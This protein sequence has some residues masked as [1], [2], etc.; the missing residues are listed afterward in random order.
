MGRLKNSLS[1]EQLVAGDDELRAIKRTLATRMDSLPWLFVSEREAKTHS[2]GGQLH[3]GVA[4]APVLKS[5]RDSEWTR[6]LAFG[7]GDRAN[8]GPR[9][10]PQILLQMLTPVN[11]FLLD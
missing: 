7:W 3:R 10:R 1:V 5:I 2:L 8:S 9:S 6:G 11:R 4:G